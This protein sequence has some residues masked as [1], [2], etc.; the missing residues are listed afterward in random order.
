MPPALRSGRFCAYIQLIL[1]SQMSSLQPISIITYVEPHLAAMMEMEKEKKVG[2][3]NKRK[4]EKSHH[5][6]PTGPCLPRL[7][8]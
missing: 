2:V 8:S 3:K 7:Q 6:P 4:R 1:K 5:K